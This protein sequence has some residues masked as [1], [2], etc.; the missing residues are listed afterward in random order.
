MVAGNLLVG[1]SGGPTP[2]INA[3]LA[4]VICAAQK[5]RQIKKVYGMEQGIEGLLAGNLREISL[6][7]KEIEALSAT[8]SSALGSCRYKV[9]DEDY[10]K[11]LQIL[12]SNNIRYFFYI[13]GN[14]S[15]DTCQQIAGLA[16]SEGYE[17]HTMGI[18]KTIDNDLPLTDHCPGFGSAARFTAVSTLSAGRDLEAMKTFD[19]VA[20]TEIMGRHAGWLTA[21]S[22]LFKKDIRDAPHLVYLPERTFRMESFL[23]DIKSIRQEIGYVFIALCEGIRDEN[24]A[25]IGT[26]NMEKDS[27]GH[28]PVAL[29]DGP[30]AYL[31]KIIKQELGLKVR[32]N[33]CGTVQRSYAES[34]SG[35]DREEAFLAGQKA[36]ELAIQGDS[37]KMITINRE[38]GNP[39]KCNFAAAPLENVANIE[40]LVPDEFINST[41]N[42]IT[43]AFKDYALPLVGNPL[44]EFFRFK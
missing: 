19:D 3:S 32:Y 35:V 40:K 2:V 33:R 7:G 41:G 5:N 20:I 37:G 36:V 22:A 23:Q 10:A 28:I 24:N 17:M 29:S 16:E 43:D 21:A 6:S 12:K 25:F 44:P 27:F 18:P 15:M 8:P 30:A 26:G 1:Q 14:D 38:D 31:A 13:G 11:I 39:Y 34:I 42:F 4:G 9:K